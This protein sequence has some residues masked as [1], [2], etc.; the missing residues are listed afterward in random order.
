MSFN[1][2]DAV[3]GHLTPDLISKASSFLGESESGIAKAVSGILPTVLSGMVSKASTGGSG[4]NEVFNAAKETNNSGFL[5]GI[6][7]IFSDGGGMLNK[8]VDLLK[9]LFGDKLSGIIGTIAS[10]AGIKT[11]SA[12]SLFSMAAPVAAGTLGKHASDNNLD[13]G[14]LASLLSSQK[15]SIL[16][17][18]PAG[19]G[20]LTSMLGIGKVADTVSSTASAG[21]QKVKEAYHHTEDTVRKAGG[22]GWLSWFLPLLLA[23]LLAWWFLLGGKS[24]CNGTAKGEG[25]DTASHVSTDHG[26]TTDVNTTN[27]TNNMPA[28]TIDTV[29]GLISYDL[30]KD[31]EFSL[32]DGV[33]FM[34][35]E[36][37]FESQLLGFIKDGTIDTVNK[38]TNWFNMFDVQFKTGGNAYTGKAEAQLKNCAAIL[39]AYPGVK[40]KLGG[41]TDNT[42]SADANTRISQQR[43][44]KVKADLVKMGATADQITEAIGYGPQFPVCEANDTPECKAR[45]RRVACKVAV[46]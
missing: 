30:G 46:K 16:N 10:F 14:G 5:G 6:G 7:N 12:S 4:A 18:L 33:K 19:L 9:G 32:P 1:I 45:N 11:S 3:K 26:T 27:T 25:S 43:A 8:G 38:S 20:G 44:D 40:I 28:V 24:S 2:L 13:A 36:R 21:H 37:G 22:F 42:G 35:A 23:A 15:S 41:Y 39:K 34:A 17:M 31:I 29:S